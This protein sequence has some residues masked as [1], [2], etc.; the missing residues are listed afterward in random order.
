[1]RRILTIH[2]LTNE[3]PQ[4][5]FANRKEEKTAITST[6]ILS[7]RLTSYLL[8]ASS[9]IVHLRLPLSRI[10]V[11]LICLLHSPFLQPFFSHTSIVISTSCS[12]SLT[13][14]FCS[15][16]F[17]LSISFAFF[18]LLHCPHFSSLVP[19]FPPAFS[20]PLT[21]PLAHS[22]GVR[23]QVRITLRARDFSSAINVL[24]LPHTLRA[25]HRVHSS[26]CYQAVW[27]D[28]PHPTTI[29]RVG[30]DFFDLQMLS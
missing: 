29:C 6:H 22:N 9:Y 4:K 25:L 11:I 24:Y 2:E 15:S 13:F 26:G 1:M 19:V 28:T 12:L 5:Q 10:S 30:H 18:Y 7:T 16:N 8:F 17:S 21:P 14:P 3:R 23:S 20:P 27:P